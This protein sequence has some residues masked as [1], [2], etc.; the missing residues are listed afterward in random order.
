MGLGGATDLLQH[1]AHVPPVLFLTP[2]PVAQLPLPVGSLAVPDSDERQQKRLSF[3]RLTPV[4]RRPGEHGARRD[5]RSTP[6]ISGSRVAT[7]TITSPSCPPSHI[8]GIACR[9]ANEGSRKCTR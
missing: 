4:A 9:F 7:A 1:H 3:H 6:P 2:E 5:H 8:A